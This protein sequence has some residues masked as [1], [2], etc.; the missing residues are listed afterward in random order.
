MEKKIFV[1]KKGG[2]YSVDSITQPGTI[3]SAASHK[4]LIKDIDSGEMVPDDFSDF[5][6]FDKTVRVTVEVIE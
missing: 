1:F 2:T 4:P 6:V 5:D 3:I